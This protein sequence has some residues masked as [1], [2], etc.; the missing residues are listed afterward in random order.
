MTRQAVLLLAATMLTGAALAQT[1][2]P[3]N[4]YG[5]AY[6]A[7]GGLAADAKIEAVVDGRALSTTFADMDGW[8]SLDIEG[9]ATGERIVFRIDGVRAQEIT[10]YE[11]AASVNLNLHKVDQSSSL[12]SLLLGGGGEGDYVYGSVAIIAVVVLALVVFIVTRR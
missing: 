10:T 12:V 3:M 7:Q 6:D 1:V 4:V 11:T 8:Y 2:P 9:I 5:I